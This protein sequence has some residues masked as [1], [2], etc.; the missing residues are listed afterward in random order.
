MVASKNHGGVQTPHPLKHL[1]RSLLRHRKKISSS[2]LIFSFLVSDKHR[3]KNYSYPI[4]LL[5][6]R[7]SRLPKSYTINGNGS[8]NYIPTD[9]YL[10]FQKIIAGQHNRTAAGPNEASISGEF[11]PEEGVEK[12]QCEPMT[13]DLYGYLSDGE[14]CTTSF[15]SNCINPSNC[16]YGAGCGNWNSINVCMSTSHPLFL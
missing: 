13:F 6:L 14:S 16:Y 2:G 11:T 8:Y 1:S 12:R 9:S 15:N 10:L 3:A 5:I 4:I 7:L